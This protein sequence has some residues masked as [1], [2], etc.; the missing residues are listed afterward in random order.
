[1]HK[2]KERVRREGKKDR[3]DGKNAGKDEKK[4]G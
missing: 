1:M 2:R 3:V 4:E